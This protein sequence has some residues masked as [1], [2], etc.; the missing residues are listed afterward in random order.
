MA[1]K[2]VLP[3]LSE[4]TRSKETRQAWLQAVLDYLGRSVCLRQ[5]EGCLVIRVDGRWRV[6]GRAGVV[7]FWRAVFEADRAVQEANWSKARLDEVFQYILLY[8]RSISMDSRRY[9][10]FKSGVLDTVTGEVVRSADRHLKCPTVRSTDLDYLPD[11][12]YG[13]TFRDWLEGQDEAQARVREWSVASAVCGE[14]GVLMTFG[15]SRT[16]KSTVAEALS[17]VLGEGALPI[18]L[19]RQWGR[20]YT[21]QF[22]GTTYLYDPDAKGSR[23][24]NEQNY[25]TLH[26]LASG[27]AIQM[28]EKGGRLRTSNNY[29]FVEVVSNAPIWL[30]F[31]Q[32]LVDRV[33]FCLYTYIRPRG[34]G[35]VTKRRLLADRQSWLNYAIT[36][37]IKYAKG[38]VRKPDL[39]NYQLYG[40]Y[41][42][43]RETN[44][45]AKICFDAGRAVSYT[46]Y[47][48]L[49]KGQA[50]YQLT[51]ETVDT[52]K[53]G[54][55][56]I[57]RRS[58][59]DFWS[60]DFKAIGGKLEADIYKPRLPL[61]EVGDIDTK[62][63][64]I[65]IPNHDAN[66]ELRRLNS[67]FK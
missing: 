47:V 56:E 12:A 39:D 54:V 22:E 48:S 2:E 17:E 31:E 13:A 35:G 3:Y 37:A 38:E 51:R 61:E 57:T 50:R 4:N 27:D 19:S 58:G 25:E 11:L 9:F 59:Q 8:G 10:E 62:K 7:E 20:F 6:F 53:Q 26:L 29:G 55:A 32:S 40:W 5:S 24:Q 36:C 16:G 18:S 49:Y 44:S 14:Y 34:D 28:E 30:R 33:T 46:E 1:T 23:N 45:Y 43:L 15:Q 42:W 52:V 66:D 60:M 64:T 63:E 67:L 65:E 41:Q 21:N